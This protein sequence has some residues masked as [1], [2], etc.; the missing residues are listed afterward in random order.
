[1]TTRSKLSPNSFLYSRFSFNQLLPLEP[2][3]YGAF[4]IFSINPSHPA[5]MLFS[6]NSSISFSFWIIVIG[7]SF[8]KSFS[9]TIFSRISLLFSY[10]TSS[11]LLPSAYIMSK[12]FTVIGYSD[13]AF[14]ILY[15]LRLCI[16]S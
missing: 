4:N 16:N 13:T 6:R 2:A 5:L 1:M 10:S 11:Q 12:K 14:S 3:L 15:F 9:I 8:A 7:T